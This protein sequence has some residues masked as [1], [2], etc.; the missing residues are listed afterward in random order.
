MPDLKKCPF[1]KF[2]LCIGNECAFFIEP[3][4]AKG[5]LG[6]DLVVDPADIYFPC[7]IAIMGKV[8]FLSHEP[9]AKQI[10]K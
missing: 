3:K 7:S 1:N 8:A 9:K 10:K 2:E 5:M 4:Y 6:N